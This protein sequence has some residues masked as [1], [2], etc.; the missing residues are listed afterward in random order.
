MQILSKTMKITSETKINTHFHKK[1]YDRFAPKT[2]AARSF[3][4]LCAINKSIIL[5]SDK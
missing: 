2:F 3:L 4:L 5:K 1:S